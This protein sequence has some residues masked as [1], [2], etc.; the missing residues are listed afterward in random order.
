MKRLVLAAAALCVALSAAAQTVTWTR[1]TFAAVDAVRID[2]TGYLF[3]SGVVAGET[4]SA[5][6]RFSRSSYT[7]IDYAECRRLAL[8][9]MSKPGQYLLSFDTYGTATIYI[10]DC[11]LERAQP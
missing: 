4:A 10:R 9:A 7:A 2:S 5:E 8:L 6:Y 1:M 11:K 3:V